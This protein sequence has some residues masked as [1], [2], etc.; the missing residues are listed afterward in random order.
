MP[1]IGPRFILCKL[2]FTLAIFSWNATF[3]WNAIFSWNEGADA[4]RKR[5]QKCW[6]L[7]LS[8]STEL[9]LAYQKTMMRPRF[10]ALLACLLACFWY[11]SSLSA[12][13]PQPV[14]TDDRPQLAIM[15]AEA[16]YETSETLPEFAQRFLQNDYRIQYVGEDP[17]AE[18]SFSNIASVASADLLLI[19]V[20]RKTLPTQ[21]L[22]VVRDF[23]AAGKPVVGIRTASH[24][25]SLRG[26]P[27]PAGC[28]QWPE[29]DAEVFG[30]NYTNHY[31]N[32]KTSTV[33]SLDAVQDHPILAGINDKSFTQIGSLYKTSPLA[34]G[35]TPLLLGRLDAE[36]EV[37][38]EPV[39]WTFQRADGGS[40]FYT[41]LG[42][43]TDFENPVF[44]KLL[45]QA[46]DWALQRPPLAAS[47]VR[48]ENGNDEGLAK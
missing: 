3:S 30:G 16:E 27:S 24:A 10:V 43:R 45:R 40:S 26:K 39:A 48:L 8:I 11:A 21:Q 1:G 23:I 4:D 37:P 34:A 9:T 29:F 38:E 5:L 25:F 32:G 7:G 42:H 46:I 6:R 19:S 14:T 36:A 17:D 41:S 18:N 22:K 13:D 12:A 2:V 44:Q 33:H 15:I 20:R 28:D 47:S 35:A 31:P